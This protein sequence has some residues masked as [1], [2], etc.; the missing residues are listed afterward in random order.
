MER[1][2][3][4]EEIPRQ[5]VLACSKTLQFLSPKQICYRCSNCSSCLQSFIVYCKVNIVLNASLVFSYSCSLVFCR[6][7]V[8]LAFI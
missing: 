6:L 5:N 1:C 8:N 3:G 2:T 4:V 7:K